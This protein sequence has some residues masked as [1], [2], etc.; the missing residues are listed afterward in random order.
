M[1]RPFNKKAYDAFDLKNKKELVSI[2]TKKGYSLVGDINE[3]H[4]KKYDVKF[5]KNGKEI[6]FEN[7]TRVNFTTIRDVYPTIHIPIRKKNTQADYYVV[8]KPELDEFLLIDNIIIDE[9]KKE[10]VT[11]VC[12]EFDEDNCYE[13]S[14]IDIPKEKA[15]LFKKIK[16][17]WVHQRL[18]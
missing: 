5:I 7:E 3:E 12:N 8:W 11:L 15:N 2:M 10:I 6:S 17:K 1:S 9:F 13:D 14:F 16:N 4:Y 18:E